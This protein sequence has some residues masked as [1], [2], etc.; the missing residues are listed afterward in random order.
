MEKKAGGKFPGPLGSEDDN[1]VNFSW[2][3]SGIDT[4]L[5]IV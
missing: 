1:D 4:G 2:C 3:S 5:I